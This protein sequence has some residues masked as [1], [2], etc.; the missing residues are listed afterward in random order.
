MIGLSNDWAYNIVKQVG[1][2]GESYER[3]VGM[4]SALKLKRGS[5]ELWTKGGLLYTPPFQ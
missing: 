3:T 1:N 5:N 4:G 2:Y